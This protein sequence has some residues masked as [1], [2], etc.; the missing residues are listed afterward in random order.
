VIQVL[1]GR[2]AFLLNGKE[3]VTAA[4]LAAAANL[5]ASPQLF[6]HYRACG[7]LCYT[8]SHNGAAQMLAHCKPLRPLSIAMPEVGLSVKNRG[9][10]LMMSAVFPRMLA[11]VSLPPLAIS[12]NVKDKPRERAPDVR[13]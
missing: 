10:D 1:P 6:R 3:P 7:S 8:I 9:I 4:R 12:P 2:P 13:P 5:P 11:Y